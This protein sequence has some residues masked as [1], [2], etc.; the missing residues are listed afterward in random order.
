M[1]QKM[2]E[3]NDGKGYSNQLRLNKNVSNHKVLG[4]QRRD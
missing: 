2:V 3:N 4:E 1:K